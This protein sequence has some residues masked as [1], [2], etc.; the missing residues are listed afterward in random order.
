MTFYR[1]NDYT[2]INKTPRFLFNF[3]NDFIHKTNKGR[4]KGI[5]SYQYQY[6]LTNTN[7]T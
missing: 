7:V 4:L 5:Y 3:P 2:N 1:N 6:P